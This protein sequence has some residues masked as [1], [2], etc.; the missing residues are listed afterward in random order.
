[1]QLTDKQL[2]SLTATGKRYEIADGLGLS[3]RV[4]PTGKIN[5]QFRYR[6]QGKPCRLDLGTYPLASLA[7]ARDR[8][9]AARKLLDQGQ[10]PVETRREAERQ[11]DEAWTV[12][13]LAND[14]LARKV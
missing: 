12:A 11:A 1:M 14:F 5:F 9:H 10:D 4:S 7:E 6:F 2:K 13:D 8:H 3:V